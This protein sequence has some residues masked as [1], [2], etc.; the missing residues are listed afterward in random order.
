M[1]QLTFPTAPGVTVNISATSGGADTT[2][3]NSAVFIVGITDRGPVVPVRVLDLIDFAAKF[4]GRN[5]GSAI[6]YDS[7][8]GAFNEGATV[9]YFCRVVGVTPT[10]G[11][12]TLV[13]R[14]GSSPPNTMRVNA[15]WPGSQSANLSIG[16]TAGTVPNSFD[17]SVYDTTSPSPTVPVEVWRDNTSVANA[18]AAINAGSSY[19]TATDMAS[20]STGTQAFPAITSGVG[21]ALSA[22]TDDRTT[23]ND[24]TWNTAA[25]AF[26]SNLGGGLLTAP[27]RYASSFHLMLEAAA[28]AQGRE[29]VLD[30]PP[31]PAA[32]DLTALALADST[33]VGHIDVADSGMGFSP[34]LLLPP[35]PGGSVPRQVPA[36][37]LVAGHIASVDGV[38]GHSNQAAMGAFGTL[39]SPIGVTVNPPFNA[40]D[41]ATINGRQGT[42][43]WNVIRSTPAIPAQIFGF[44]TLSTAARSYFGANVRETL[45]LKRA[46]QDIGDGYIGA[47]I[48]G[49]GRVFMDL[50]NDIGALLRTAY[51]ANALFGRTAAQAYGVDVGPTVNTQATIAAGIIKARVW[52]IPS[53][54]GERV[55]IDLVRNPVPT[56]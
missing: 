49:Q 20:S 56:T 31:T 37:A 3:T 48:D 33:G 38:A 36:S 32:A 18:V 45:A 24:T 1:S 11:L 34:W 29:A 42:T 25:T 26:P 54:T 44:R 19:I 6:A 43:G 22:G 12:L 9:V 52:F 30:G 21:T 17:V 41:R 14:T 35:A 7:V 23:A 16:I 27:G 50:A 5:A 15:A 4:G 40:T 47:M 2:A 28:V 13:D 55:I 46:I 10:T 51:D 39:V 53:P 8:E